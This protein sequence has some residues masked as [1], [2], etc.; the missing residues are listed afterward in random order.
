MATDD[1]PNADTRCVFILY[2]IPI[3]IVAGYLIG[4]RLDNLGHVRFRLGWVAV[5][6]LAIQLVL[7]SAVAD[8]WPAELVR[9]GYVGSTALVLAVVIANIRLTGVP[10]VVLGA[11]SNLVAVVANGGAMPA[12]AGA[13]AA[14]G[15][16]VGGHTS[17]IALEHPAF[18]PLTDV[19]AM[20]AWMPMANIFS[21]GDV[22]IGIGVVVAIAAAMRPADPSPAPIE[23]PPAA[24]R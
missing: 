5:I 2:A 14:L 19:Y 7:F 4:G 24:P 21:V 10:L 11:L 23:E 22:V 20:P 15:F 9:G 12:G 17:S 18:E 1:P 3:G 6:A 13:L 16:G 8:G